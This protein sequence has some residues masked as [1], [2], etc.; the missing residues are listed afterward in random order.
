MSTDE[1]IFCCACHSGDLR[2]ARGMLSQETRQSRLVFVNAVNKGGWTPLLRAAAMGH[3]KVVEFLLQQRADIDVAHRRDGWTALHLAAQ[4]GAANVVATLVAG[5]ANVASR[6]S[7]G[8]TPLHTAVHSD[9]S[10]ADVRHALLRAGACAN[11]P[12]AVTGESPVHVAA[13]S[14]STRALRQLLSAKGSVD[15]P[16]T[17]AGN[18]PLFT[19]LGSRCIGCVR[20]LLECGTSVA[21]RNAAG[22]TPVQKATELQHTGAV[23]IFREVAAQRREQRQLAAL[24]LARVRPASS[25]AQVVPRFLW[26][27]LF[28]AASSEVEQRQAFLPLLGTW[29]N[30]DAERP[31]RIAAAMDEVRRACLLS[32]RLCARSCVCVDADASAPV[33]IT[34]CVLC[35]R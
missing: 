28:G 19:A 8:E 6:N 18:T 17:V 32:T 27:R 2:L 22:L 34:V 16:D 7:A 1:H 14:F 29:L 23:T 33:G 12:S 24:L 3:N 21:Q 31:A 10:N 5:R 4:R 11:T 30:S 13:R 20:L 25:V 35:V 9:D 15:A 26:R